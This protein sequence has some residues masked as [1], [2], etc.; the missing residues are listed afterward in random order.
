MPSACHVHDQAVRKSRPAPDRPARPVL[1]D[2]TANAWV[3]GARCGVSSAVVYGDRVYLVDLV[4]RRYRRGP[5]DSQS[6][7][8]SSQVSP[9]LTV[10]ARSGNSIV[11]GERSEAGRMTRKRAG[12]KR[13]RIPQWPR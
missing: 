10:T 7:S 3:D 13:S 1:P 4:T 8:T 6:S 12:D 5:V 2:A 11:M 9:G